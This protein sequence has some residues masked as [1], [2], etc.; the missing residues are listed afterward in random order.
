MFIFAGPLAG[1]APLWHD[2]RRGEPIA[3]AKHK[4]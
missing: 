4:E 3:P 1:R 2:R